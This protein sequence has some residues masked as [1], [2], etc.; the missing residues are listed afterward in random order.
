MFL[1]RVIDILLFYYGR[2]ASRGLSSQLI[3]ISVRRNVFRM[4]DG[5][6]TVFIKFPTFVVPL[7]LVHSLKCQPLAK[8]RQIRR[9]RQFRYF[10][11][12]RHFH[13]TPV[14]SSIGRM[15]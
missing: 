14:F 10:R 11:Q 2:N 15:S 3:F 6:I 5:H 4:S 1:E 7:Y 9:F 8:F 12:I 13:C